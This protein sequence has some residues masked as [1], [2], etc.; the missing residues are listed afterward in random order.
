MNAFGW[1]TSILF[2]AA[3]VVLAYLLVVGL[4]KVPKGSPK[5]IAAMVAGA[6]IGV[7]GFGGLMMALGSVQKAGGT[8]FTN[9]SNF[10]TTGSGGGLTAPNQP[11][12]PAPAPSKAK[13]P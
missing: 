4:L 3:G 9:L 7:F 5:V 2:A 12:A 10:D 6:F 8:T 13:A 1:V 11:A